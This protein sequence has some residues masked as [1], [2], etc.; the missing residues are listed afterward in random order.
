MCWMIQSWWKYL[1]NVSG[2]NNVTQY[3][4]EEC[5]EEY[6]HANPFDLVSTQLCPLEEKNIELIGVKEMCNKYLK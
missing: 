6:E 1:K 3:K 4:S 2:R 5:F